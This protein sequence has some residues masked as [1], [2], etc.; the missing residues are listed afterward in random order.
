[1]RC[2][3]SRAKALFVDGLKLLLAV[4]SFEPQRDD[5]CVDKGKSKQIAQAAK[6][7]ETSQVHDSGHHS[8]GDDCEPRALDGN[9]RN[10]VNFFKH[11]EEEP[12]LRVAV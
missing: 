11:L 10:R 1:M 6:L 9:F 12:V 4:D 7:G 5:C 8:N 2:I 3:G